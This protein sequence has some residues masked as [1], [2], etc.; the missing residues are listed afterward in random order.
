MGAVYYASCD[1]ASLQGFEQFIEPYFRDTEFDGARVLARLEDVVETLESSSPPYDGPAARKLLVARDLRRL[2]DVLRGSAPLADPADSM[3]RNHERFESSFR[4]YGLSFS[5]PALH[6]VETFP[7]PYDTMDWTATSP[8]AADEREYGIEA[9][10]YFK[11]KHLVP[12][13]SDILLAHEMTHA[14]IGQVNPDL[15]GRGLEE[16]IA[17]V[18]GE[19][20]IGSSVFG[21]DVVYQYARHHWFDQRATQINR[22]YADYARMAAAIYHR[23]GIDALIEL[24]RQ[25]REKIKEAEQATLAGLAP[26]GLP[27]GRWDEEFGALVDRVCLQTV[28]DLTVS[29]LTQWVATFAQVGRSS[30]DVAE[31]AGVTPEDAQKSL[32]EL[33][34]EI[35]VIVTGDDRIDYSDAGFITGTQSLRYLV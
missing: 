2:A 7:A 8:D 28:R 27:T 3:P 24:I 22:L 10:N 18:V 1:F 5:S 13:G 30:S 14:I 16:G 20:L 34:E 19:L 29:P 11:E 4:R 17:V 25:G 31:L 12:V 35:F 9:G 23:C 32:K 33:Q 26:S 21:P 6:I 15:L